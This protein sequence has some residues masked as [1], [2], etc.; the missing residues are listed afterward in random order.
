MQDY[1]QVLRLLKQ[2]CPADKPVR[3]RRVKVPKD[4]FGDCDQYKDYYLIR[5]CRKLKEKQA[6]DILLHEYAHA[7]SW[8]KSH[9][10]DHCNEWGKA[11]SKVYRLYLKEFV[12]KT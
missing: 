6:I 2:K 8:D 10:D 3:V 5:I 9:S 12:Y 1:R 7:I 11:Y 4:R